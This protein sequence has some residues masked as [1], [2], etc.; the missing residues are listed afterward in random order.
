MEINPSS[1]II[2]A[3]K[4]V[5]FNIEEMGWKRFKK[6]FFVEGEPWNVSRIW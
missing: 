2:R 5:V 4:I 1:Q 3:I 6:I